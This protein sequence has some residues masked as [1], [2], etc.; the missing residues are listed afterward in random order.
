MPTKRDTEIIVAA[1]D[2]F[3][4]QKKRLNAQIA[5]LRQM[6]NPSPTD[7]SAPVPVRRR[8]SAAARAKIAAAQRK[9]WAESRK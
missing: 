3:E 5:E 4:Q 7:G 9:R 1:I 2:G 8:M 6:L